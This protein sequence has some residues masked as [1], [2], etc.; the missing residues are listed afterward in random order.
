M[1]AD[2]WPI[3]WGGKLVGWMASPG[4]DMPHYYGR[5]VAADCPAA[6]EFLAALRQVGI[7]DEGLKV[8]VSGFPGIAH[9]HPDDYDGEIDIRWDFRE[10]AERQVRRREATGGLRTLPRALRA[11]H[12]L[13]APT[14]GV[15]LGCLQG[16]AGTWARLPLVR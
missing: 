2:R 15:G 7:E 11:V 8:L 4:V 3:T 16:V 5:W 9:C 14:R 1:A 6:G 13:P 10:R 12:V